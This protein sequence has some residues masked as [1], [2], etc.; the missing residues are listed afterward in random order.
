MKTMFDTSMPT[1]VKRIRVQQSSE[2]NKGKHNTNVNEVG[3]IQR[4]VLPE[5]RL[6]LWEGRNTVRKSLL[7]LGT[8]DFEVDEV[9]SE[10]T[11]DQA[12]QRLLGEKREHCNT[13]SR[14][15]K[16]TWAA[17]APTAQ[18]RPMISKEIS[19]QVENLGRTRSTTK[20]TE[21]QDEQQRTGR[22]L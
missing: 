13:W 10:F 2:I 12:H 6:S 14:N 11:K 15:A 16:L 20:V 5:I 18:N 1:P 7:G 22:V 19:V 8:N 3:G 4:S 17:P 21:K 9:L